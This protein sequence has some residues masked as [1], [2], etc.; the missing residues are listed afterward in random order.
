MNHLVRLRSRGEEVVQERPGL[1]VEVIPVMDSGFCRGHKLGVLL[2]GSM[3][4]M[5]VLWMRGY[6]VWRLRMG[7]QQGTGHA[8]RKMHVSA[9]MVTHSGNPSLVGP[10]RTN[11]S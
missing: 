3:E 5:A 11:V 4:T 7:W 6:Q 10:V 9:V 2:A 1:T 8:E